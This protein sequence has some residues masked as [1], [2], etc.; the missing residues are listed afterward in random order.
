MSQNI[1]CRDLRVYETP[2]LTDV[3]C[4]SNSY[5]PSRSGSLKSQRQASVTPTNAPD[6]RCWRSGSIECPDTA[7]RPLFQPTFLLH[8]VCL[9]LFCP[10]RGV[11]RSRE[12]ADAEP[13]KRFTHDQCLAKAKECRDMARH[14][15]NEG[16]RTMLEHMAETWTRI[17]ADI[18]R[19]DGG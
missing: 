2:G 13:S 19:S 4:C 11:R 9:F 8:S 16:H 5:Q 15:A 10:A 3:R 18:K 7:F 6:V 14:T 1:G 17:A 12:M